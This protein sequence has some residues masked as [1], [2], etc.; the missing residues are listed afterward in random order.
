MRKKP[1]LAS[2][3]ARQ[4]IKAASRGCEAFEPGDIRVSR[5]LCGPTF[6]KS[7]SKQ[8]Q[9]EAGYIL[10]TAIDE[11]WLPLVKLGR[12]SSNHKRYERE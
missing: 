3:F 12:S 10:S 2:N 9:I 6:W 1:N 7:L 11:A 5:Q 4:V 8:Q